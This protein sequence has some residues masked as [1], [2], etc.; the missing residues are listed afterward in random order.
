MTVQSFLDVSTIHLPHTNVAK[1]IPDYVLAEGDE[2]LF[3]WIP[4][5]DADYVV[6]PDWFWNICK[7]AIQQ[8]CYYVRFTP[9]GTIYSQLKE[10]EWN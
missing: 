7:F 9:N 10:F 8:G 3:V 6:I 5:V 4:D 2:D 1:E